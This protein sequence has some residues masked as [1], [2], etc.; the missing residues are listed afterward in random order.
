M[1]EN[2]PAPG[3][4]L[5]W[6]RGYADGS[7]RLAH[8]VVA[9]G[10]HRRGRERQQA[11]LRL[12]HRRG[13]SAE[14][15][16]IRHHLHHR[17]ERQQNHRHGHGDA[18]QRLPPGGQVRRNQHRLVQGMVRAGWHKAHDYRGIW[19][20][21]GRALQDALGLR[22]RRVDD[23]Q[24]GTPRHGH[25][26]RSEQMERQVR[27]A[28]NL[29]GRHGKRRCP[30]RPRLHLQ[31]PGTERAERLLLPAGIQRS[32][33]APERVLHGRESRQSEGERGERTRHGDAAELRDCEA[34]HRSREALG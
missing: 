17:P 34:D 32:P 28:G 29:H 23:G 12:L 8:Q 9:A 31:P 18:D 10:I 27:G 4:R 26:G 16:H 3:R 22:Q 6:P 2:P 5:R 15:H 33:A 21:A 19:R 20:R 24:H 1:G 25:A 11:L 14:L 13:Q 30:K 7:E